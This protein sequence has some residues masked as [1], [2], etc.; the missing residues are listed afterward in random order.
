MSRIVSVG[1]ALPP[2]S[3]PQST[4]KEFIREL[5][6]ETVPEIERL[7]GIFDNSSISTRHFSVPLEWLSAEHSFAERNCLFRENALQL[8]ESAVTSCLGKAGTTKENI[9]HII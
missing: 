8:S 2:F 3:Y 5:F 4:V 7:S 9:D 1:T 6:K